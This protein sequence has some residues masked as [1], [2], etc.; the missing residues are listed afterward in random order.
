MM[1]PF[2]CSC[3]SEATD[4]LMVTRCWMRSYSVVEACSFTKS[5]MPSRFTHCFSVCSALRVIRSHLKTFMTL[6][7]LSLT[8]SLLYFFATHPGAAA[9]C[10]P[11]RRA[12]TH[13]TRRLVSPLAN[14]GKLRFWKPQ[15]SQSWC[16]NGSA[17]A[18]KVPR[19]VPISLSVRSRSNSPKHSL[20][21]RCRLVIS[22]DTLS[23]RLSGCAAQASIASITTPV[24]DRPCCCGPSACA[25][26]PLP[27]RGRW[28]GRLSDNLCRGR[29]GDPVQR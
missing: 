12:A 8:L 3:L 9:P 11:C 15:K 1:L 20:C 24:S 2:I 23:G 18:M 21:V 26:L 22:A 25:S 27:F 7:T 4:S 5:S 14:T 28:V 13:L 16:P 19:S 10:L 17:R 29:I 6:T